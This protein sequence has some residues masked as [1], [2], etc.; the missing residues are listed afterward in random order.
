MKQAHDLGFGFRDDSILVFT[1]KMIPE[2]LKPHP[3]WFHANWAEYFAPVAPVFVE[4]EHYNLSRERGAWSDEKLVESVEAYRA[5]WLSLHGW[6]REIYDGSHE[7]YARAARRIG[8]RFELREVEYPDAVSLG[9]Q[10]TI[11]S[12]WANVGVARC[13]KG[14]TLAW[15]LVDAKGRVA[16]VCA[17]ESFDFKDAQPALGGKECPVSLSSAC[18]FGWTGEIPQINDG[19]WVYTVTKGIG[20]YA[21]DTR[22]PTLTPGDYTLC[23]SLGEPDG[24][25]RLALPLKGGQAR[26]YPIGKI[27]VR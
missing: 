27:V 19:V 2:R 17:D 16:W 8:Y 1:P 4:H 26:R 3:W 24:T 9:K 21:S 13:Y 5:T 22:V 11:R 20:N 10:V 14:A 12:K 23:V 25:P 15:S 6:P 18:T 7:A